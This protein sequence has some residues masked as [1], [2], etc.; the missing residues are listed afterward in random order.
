MRPR[1]KE[2]KHLHREMENLGVKLSSGSFIEEN[3][4]G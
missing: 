4:D 3:Y 1:H 2:L